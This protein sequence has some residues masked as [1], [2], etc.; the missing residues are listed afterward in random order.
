MRKQL[1]GHAVLESYAQQFHVLHL[2]NRLLSGSCL[3][4]DYSKTITKAF[5]STL[6]S[7]FES[8]AQNSRFLFDT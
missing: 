6:K 7:A 5:V 3:K 4:P 1:L 2:A 8:A